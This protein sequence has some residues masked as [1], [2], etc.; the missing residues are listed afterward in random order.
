MFDNGDERKVEE[1]ATYDYCQEP[2]FVL[3]V[4]E[5]KGLILI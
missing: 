5:V 2:I 4:E 3:G 1:A